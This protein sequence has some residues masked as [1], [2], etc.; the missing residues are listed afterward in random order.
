LLHEFKDFLDTVPGLSLPSP[1]IWSA[2]KQVLDFVDGILDVDDWDVGLPVTTTDEI[3]E[4]KGS[5]DID[6]LIIGAVPKPLPLKRPCNL[7]YGVERYWMDIRDGKQVTAK[8][9]LF[10]E[11]AHSRYQILHSWLVKHAAKFG[12]VDLFDVND[13][14]LKE[15]IHFLHHQNLSLN[16]V[17]GY[18]DNL[19]AMFGNLATDGYSLAKLTVRV[20]PEATHFVYNSEEELKFLLNFKFSHEA[21]VIAR[22]IFVIQSYTGF[23]V[24]T[25]QIFLRSP[26][27]YL[28]KDE[29]GHI[30]QIRTNKTGRI[31]AV[32]VK[33][34]VLEILQRRN[35]FFEAAY[36]ERYYNTLIKIMAREAGLVKIVPYAATYGRKRREFRD[37]KW[38]LMA[39]HTARRNFA[40]NAFLAGVPVEHIMF[41]T[42]HTTREAFMRYIRCEGIAV[43]KALLKSKNPFF[44]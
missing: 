25:L 39:S 21:L 23:R 6:E 28:H 40:T 44:N 38:E 18:V 27:L 9:R 15:F 19:H 33:P 42:G 32:P 22:D 12:E 35:F 26:E 34:I 5:I 1:S 14:W 20:H 8:G 2:D 3:G 10:V 36:Y 11:G 41:V 29:D 16:T 7:T 43:A 30:I 4:E 37:E 13:K 24:G 17:S 31:V